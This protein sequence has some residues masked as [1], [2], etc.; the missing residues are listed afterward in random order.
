LLVILAVILWQADRSPFGKLR[1]VPFDSYI[2]VLFLAL[3]A[4]SRLFLEAFR[5]DAALI[6]GGLRAAQV[7]ALGVLLVAVWFLYRRRF[8]TA[9]D[10]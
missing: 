8:S 1:T 10:A 9:S 4:G 3:Y 2:F 7:I 6:S 5:A